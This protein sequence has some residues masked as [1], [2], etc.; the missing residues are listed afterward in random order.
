MTVYKNEKEKQKDCEK[1]MQQW[2][3]KKKKK[4]KRRRKSIITDN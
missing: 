4:R 2:K 1:Y 3:K